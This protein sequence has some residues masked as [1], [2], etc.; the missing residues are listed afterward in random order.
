MER[1]PVFE[2]AKE[3]AA[4]GREGLARRAEGRCQLLYSS[5]ATL[6]Y[7]SPGAYGFGVKRAGLLL[8]ESVMLLVAPGCCGRN[9]AIV[10]SR[11]GYDGRMFYLQMDETDLVTGRHLKQIPQAVCEIVETVSP[12]PK[13]VLVCF[14]CVDALLGTDLEAICRT[15]QEQCGARVVPSYMYA[16]T[17]EGKNPPMVGIRQALYSLLEKPLSEK[18]LSE[19]REEQERGVNL[20]GFFAPLEETCELRDFLR[21]A[22]FTA[23]RELSA[24]E[25]LEAYARMGGSELNLVLSAE[26]NPAA[27]DLRRRLGTPYAELARLYQL[28]RIRKQY[29]LLAAALG[30]KWDDSALYEQ[31]FGALSRFKAAHR[32]LR[33]AVGQM[34]NANPFE[35]ALAFTKYGL[36]VP[37]VFA[38]CVES[39]APFLRELADFSPETRV[40]ESL[41]P[42]MVHFARG[43]EQAELT[44]GM[45][46]GYYVPGAPNVPWNGDRQPFGY[47]GLQSLLAEMEQALRTGENASARSFAKAQGMETEVRA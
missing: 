28:G 36:S 5:P 37:A 1:Q 32:G 11:A 20:L 22:G 9:S 18:P 19:K 41:A 42:S 2:T 15:A 44:V 35:L 27:E 12:R 24:C 7:N 33:V 17:R 3:L 47:A 34:L 16:I 21:A 4:L 46:A 23:V 30:A 45:D 26:A 39:D 8:P 38:A 40:Y 13:A 29:E 6:Q 10:G 14:T 31:T 25:T 43:R